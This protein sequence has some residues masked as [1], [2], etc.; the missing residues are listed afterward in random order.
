MVSLVSSLSEDVVSDLLTLAIR[1]GRYERSSIDN[2]IKHL[3]FCLRFGQIEYIRNTEGKLIGFTTW[4]RTNKPE[5]AKMLCQGRYVIVPFITINK[6]YRGKVDLVRWIRKIIRKNMAL[7]RLQGVKR[8]LWRR[9]AK[10]TERGK[11]KYWRHIKL[12]E[13]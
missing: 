12:Q 9:A 11:W 1:S 2:W 4:Y 7:G 5:E 13:V 6:D 3:D 8:I 10:D